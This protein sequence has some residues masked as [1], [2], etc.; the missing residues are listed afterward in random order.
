MGDGDMRQMVQP[1]QSMTGFAR[2]SGNAQ[3]CSF[4]CEIRSVNARGLDVRLRLAPGLDAIEADIR[5]LVSERLSR[6]AVNVAVTLTREQAETEVVV[7]QQAL[8]AVLDALDALSGR[9]EADRPRLDGILALNGVLDIRQAPLSPDAEEALHKAVLEAV[10][11]ALDD[12]IDS[13]RAEGERLTQ[14][15]IAR[16]E[17]IEALTKS[18]LEHPSRQRDAILTRLK[19]QIEELKSAGAGLDESRLNQ[20]ALLLATRADIKEELDRLS[21]H[22]GAA[23]SLISKGGP[24]GRKLDF[25]AQEFNREANTLCSKSNDVTLTA[26][27]LDLK[28]AIDQ[29]REQIQ[30]IE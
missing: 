1:L 15:L 30:N 11:V 4:V 17:E 14:V 13:R 29:L 26:I 21:A 16:V 18:A 9:I 3:G 10:D 6:G 27:G 22:T 24:A 20:E 12:L 23:R 2:A 8:G 7:N 28:A 25:L 19:A 5:R